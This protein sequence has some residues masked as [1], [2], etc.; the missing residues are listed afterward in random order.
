M[1]SKRLSKISRLIQKELG[2]H[3]QR[4]ARSFGGAIIAVTVVR[5][6]PDLAQCRAY[7]SIFPPHLVQASFEAISEQTPLIRHALAQSTRHQLRRTPELEF[8]ID[9]SLDY[10]ENID[11]LLLP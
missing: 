2:E 3:F 7:L 6:T 1:D 5:V 8:F 4:N 10:A 11:R 9:D